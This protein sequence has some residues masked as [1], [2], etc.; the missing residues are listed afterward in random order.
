[1]DIF[2]ILRKHPNRSTATTPISQLRLK[3]VDIELARTR[4]KI[5]RQLRFLFIY[6]IVYI[7]MWIVPFVSHGLQYSD[8]FAVN[9]PFALTCCTTIFVCM[10]AAVDAWL[11]STREK[12]WRHISG[13]N[14]GFWV[15]LKFWSDWTGT[16]KRRV[17]D[18]PGK[19]R[20]EAVREAAAAH[21]RREDE[22]RIYEA[23]LS[24]TPRNPVA[25][26][27]EWWDTIGVDGAMSAVWEEVSSLHEDIIVFNEDTFS[28]R[29]AQ[30]SAG[31]P[32]IE[33]E[34]A[35]E[36]VESL[37]PASPIEETVLQN[38]TGKIRGESPRTHSA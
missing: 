38:E 10:Q 34:Q 23:R 29:T 31:R 26:R 11:F 33:G 16:H 24:T 21:Q 36:E 9:P 4:D 13:T 15:S 22:R 28:D 20:E 2:T 25:R 6:P 30:G 27:A 7:G 14:G 18:G 19:T 35:P 8:R 37:D 17:V 3:L 1:M 32:K 5:Q 12:P